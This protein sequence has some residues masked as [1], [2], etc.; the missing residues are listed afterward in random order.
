MRYLF[1]LLG[2]LFSGCA[3]YSFT[4]AAIPEHIRT[5]AIPLF[6][7]RSQSTIP[8]LDQQV[9]EYLIDQFVHQTRLSLVTSPDEADAVLEGYIQQ[10]INRPAAVGGEEKAV[11]NRVT[12]TLFARYFDRVKKKE[13]FARSFTSFG[14]YD[15]VKEGLEGEV[16]AAQQ[17]LQNIAQDIFNAATSDW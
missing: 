3:Y 14:E 10:Y 9:T 16:R 6:E 7:D 8:G 11:V 4:G 17:A 13:V 5:I 15:P 1:L 12:I 2:I